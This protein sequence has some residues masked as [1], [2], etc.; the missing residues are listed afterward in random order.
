[1]VGSRGEREE[2]EGSC[3]WVAILAVVGCSI[4]FVAI[5]FGSEKTKLGIGKRVALLT[6]GG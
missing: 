1:M 3:S 6:M 2:V 4:G 5:V